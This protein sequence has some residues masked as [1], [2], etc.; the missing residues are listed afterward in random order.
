MS[1]VQFVDREAWR[2]RVDLPRLGHVV[3]H[4]QF[5]GLAVHHTVTLVADVDQDGLIAGDIDDAAAH[6]RYLQTVRAHDL[7]ADV[8]YSFVVFEGAGPDD[9]IVAEGRGYGRTGAHTAGYN[10]SRYGVA[11]AGD[12]TDRTPTPGMVAAVRWLGSTLADPAGAELTLGHRQVYPTAC[13]GD[14]AYPLL[15][16]MQP[17]FGHLAPTPQE[18][19]DVALKIITP[20]DANAVFLGTVYK[21]PSGAELVYECRWLATAA[22][23]AT[24]EAHGLERFPCTVAGLRN[25]VLTG[26]M[27]YGDDRHMWTSDD[28]AARS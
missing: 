18:D 13:P 9:A 19:E 25:V 8:P 1:A 26:P 27:P 16:H 3:P 12:F 11:F 6:M 22:D 15:V 24:Y 7:G 17:P 21:A 14:A 5:V 28:W 10:S 2:A 4:E 23:V 20:S